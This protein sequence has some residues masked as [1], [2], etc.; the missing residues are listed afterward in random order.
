MFSISNLFNQTPTWQNVDKDFR[1]PYKLQ[2]K[3]PPNS[4]DTPPP[5]RPPYLLPSQIQ[6]TPM[7]PETALRQEASRNPALLND[8]DFLLKAF[9]NDFHLFVEFFKQTCDVETVYA[10]VSEV[11]ELLEYA[12]NT[13]AIKILAGKT[14]ETD[15]PDAKTVQNSI[16]E[17]LPYV[18]NQLAFALLRRT[19]TLLPYTNE[20]LKYNSDIVLQ[21][22]KLYVNY[23][24]PEKVPDLYDENGNKASLLI[25]LKGADPENPLFQ[26]RGFLNDAQEYDH[27]AKELLEQL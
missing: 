22:L 3:T 15:N 8:V 6:Q 23:G 5:I 10:F 9:T 7:D 18:N 24:S 26:D 27:Y 11:P 14:K 19:P 25:A 1:P 4:S 21:V 13:M 2:P 20:Q 12:D 17:Y 16:K